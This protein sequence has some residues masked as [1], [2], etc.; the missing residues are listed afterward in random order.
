MD[1]KALEANKKKNESSVGKNCLG[2]I[3]GLLMK[4][5]ENEIQSLDP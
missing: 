1:G 3:D 4:K 5:T 2:K